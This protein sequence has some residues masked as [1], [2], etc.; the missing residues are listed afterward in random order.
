MVLAA[1][2]DKAGVTDYDLSPEEIG[3]YLYDAV[4]SSDFSYSGLTGN[5]MTWSEDGKCTKAP[6]I[7]VLNG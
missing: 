7:V 1:A 5:G 6:K 3:N 2:L 4:T